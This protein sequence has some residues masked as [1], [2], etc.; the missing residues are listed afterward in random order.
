MPD[1]RTDLAR[2]AREQLPDLPGVAENSWE[3]GS[4]RVTSI[5]IETEEAAKALE[6]PRGVYISLDAPGIAARE[7]KS[8]A[9]ASKALAE[10]LAAQLSFLAPGDEV[11]VLGL[12]NRQV[13][14]DSLGPRVV[15]KLFV[16]RHIRRHAPELA[17]AGMRPVAAMAPGVLGVTGFE[18][19]EV[20]RGL[21]ACVA[22]KAL[23][24]IDALASQRAAR[25]NTTIQLGNRGILPGG[26]VGN[27][28]QGITPETV[29]LPVI[30]V[31]V[32][33]VVY[34]STIASET[35]AAINEKSGE[36][37]RNAEAEE[38]L[39]ALVRET[40]RA[41]FGD[42]IVTPKDIDLMIGD[43]AGILA[44]GVNRM[45]HGAAYDEIAT[46]LS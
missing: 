2:E 40:V 8:F 45:L 31:G 35:L 13:T 27:H 23:I 12:G 38:A 29:G 24:C 1:M 9:D 33:T 5:E 28:R 39:D 26:G 16:T 10:A 25:I 46:L 44:E 30:A 14:P 6:K 41:R 37:N 19:L 3:R 34:A 11:L 42:M 4:V 32:P 18:T 17:P 43:A 36:K 22:P 20:V 21:T 7:P 15:E